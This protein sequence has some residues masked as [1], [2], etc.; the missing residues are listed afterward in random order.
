[1]RWRRRSQRDF[2]E[3]IDAHLEL[4]ANQLVHGGMTPGD[5]RSAAR[6]K[7]GNVGTAQDRY[8][9]TGSFGW[10]ERLGQDIGYAGRMLHKNLA[11]SAIAIATLSIGIAATTGI[12]AVVRG[13]V[14]EPPPFRDP[15]RLVAVLDRKDGAAAWEFTSLDRFTEWRRDA[16]SFS[17]LAAMHG[18]AYT[19]TGASA[20]RRVTAM[21][22]SPTFFPMLGVTPM[23]GGQ[24]PADADRLGSNRWLLLSHRFWREEFGGDRSVIGRTV[25]QAAG[26]PAY[27]II[28]ILPQ[29][30]RIGGTDP[31][32]WMPLVDDPASPYRKQHEWLVF[33]RLNAGVSIDA[34]QSEVGALASRLAE[35][36]TDP[37]DASKW[38]TTVVPMQRFYTDRGNT[39]LIVW[40]LFAAVALLLLIAC[41]NVGNLL[42]A[43]GE[44]RHAEFA[45]RVA[46]GAS[47]GRVA[48]QVVTESLAI[49]LLG[50]VAGFLLSIP[51]QQTLRALAPPLPTFREDAIRMD[52]PV[53]LFAV[54][55]GLV[56][57]LAFGLASGP[58][59]VSS[60]LSAMLG[61]GLQ[62]G[63]GRRGQLNRH[64]ALVT[65]EIAVAVVL[66]SA[67]G[68][69]TE[70]FR[71]LSDDNPGFDAR[72]VVTVTACCLDRTRYPNLDATAA[73]H[74]QVLSRLRAIPGV[75]GVAE[76][77]GNT[78]IPTLR[79]GSTGSSS[80]ES[81]DAERSG[82]AARPTA[83][84]VFVGGDYFGTL[85]IPMVTGRR[86]LDVDGPTT[87]PVVVVN[88]A[89]AREISG[90]GDAVGR[91]VR[92][93]SGDGANVW[94]EVIGVA[95]NAKERGLG[96]A[97]VPTMYLP[98][99]QVDVGYPFFI[100]RTRSAPLA[101]LPLI[102]N[103]IWSVD[104]T[105]PLE[106]GQTLENALGAPLATNRFVMSL[107]AVFA[108]LALA[109]SAIGVFGVTGY[110]VA[111]R[112]REIGVRVA[113]GARPSR[114]VG[115]IMRQEMRFAVLGVAIGIAATVALGR[116]MSQLLYGIGA[117]N[118][119]VITAAA[120]VLLTIVAVASGIPSLG[121][122]RIDP[123]TVLRSD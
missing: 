35:T 102:R 18:C 61:A 76:M 105:L 114:V 39:R 7:F 27:T 9:D 77:S 122:T 109:L 47:S 23:A 106:D 123:A 82:A 56:A 52:L 88:E 72:N 20:P 67:A 68:L 118:P 25:P 116:V 44:A 113:L 14:L 85:R 75:E 120:L 90:S 29:G 37:V 69:L 100:V 112:R 21:C 36:N 98:S 79:Q 30:M 119:V 26:G 43:R 93:A 64:G 3:E 40:V 13:V 108:A 15:S 110:A 97:T 78:A 87:T 32:V 71:R 65:A 73:F 55:V 4:E 12:F 46:L 107:L 101:V 50:G 42:L 104:Q 81:R 28:G 92:P 91:F 99:T 89:L 86:F 60:R 54:V 103:A 59:N 45:L 31:D 34:A 80:I 17:T 58:R 24:F 1:M 94:R 6:R 70:S 5:A 74:S 63:I 62:R 22:V 16:K 41:A 66:L 83:D 96:T 48:Q 19:M 2:E 10:L 111:R 51:A 57:S 11:F 49:G 8:H 53:L 117:T 33:G 121:A 38:G 84:V 115:L 95:R